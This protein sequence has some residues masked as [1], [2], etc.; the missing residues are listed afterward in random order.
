MNKKIIL[1]LFIAAYLISIRGMGFKKFVEKA[2]KKSDAKRDM[3]LNKKQDYWTKMNNLSYLI[4]RVDIELNAPLY[5]FD[6]PENQDYSIEYQKYGADLTINQLLPTS[7][8]LNST[9]SFDQYA[10]YK[11]DGQKIE[12]IDD[13]NITIGIKQIFWGT[14]KGYHYLKK[15]F[16]YRELNKINKKEYDI[17]ILRKAYEK[18][19]DYLLAKKTKEL[20]KKLFK[21]YKDI[22]QSAKHKYKMGIFDLIT[23]NRIKKDYKFNEINFL[24]SK[25]RFVNKKE[26]VENFIN[27]KFDNLEYKV[28]NIKKK[29]FN[30]KQPEQ[31]IKKQKITLDNAYRNYKFSRSNYEVKLFG[32]INSNLK[33]ERS[34]TPVE[35]DLKQDYYEIRLGVS[36]PLTNLS[37]LA[38]FNQKKVNY[39][40]EKNK[41]KDGLENINNNYKLLISNL[42]NYYKKIKLYKE[43]LPDLKENYKAG[44]N[45]FSMGMI[46]LDE[47]KSIETEYINAEIEYLKTIKSY[48]LTAI[49]LSKYIGNSE[50]ILEGIL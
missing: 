31:I 8:E 2:Y 18:Y 29:Y 12:N 23:Y 7:T 4:P 47:L 41:I 45:R 13:K 24:E 5:S 34:I 46:T 42:K 35:E 38:G 49:K 36:V 27:E 33:D 9:I 22:Y 20:H 50:K 21:R 30:D 16:N 37:K 17:E 10:Y 19:I 1:I 25:R 48:N 44:R 26:E 3:S 15:W 28:I 39:L 40:I 43:I 32:Q 14:N 11:A 6:E